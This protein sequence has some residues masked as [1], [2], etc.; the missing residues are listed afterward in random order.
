MTALAATPHSTGR[1]LRDASPAN[2]FALT[3]QKKIKSGCNGSAATWC[4][5][6]HMATPEQW[7]QPLHGAKKKGIVWHVSFYFVF[8]AC[9][10]TSLYI[11]LNWFRLH[12]K[13]IFES[14]RGSQGNQGKPGSQ[15][16]QTNEGSERK[17]RKSMNSKRP[18]KSKKSRNAKKAR[19]LN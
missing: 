7:P 11:V 4:T 9:F 17:S 14:E 6:Q 18:M 16:R 3:C 12:F 13:A 10:F 2:A 15:G 5:R 8:L 19:G 1:F